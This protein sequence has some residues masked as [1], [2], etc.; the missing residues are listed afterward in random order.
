MLTPKDE[1]W[2]YDM[3]WDAIQSETD[4]DEEQEE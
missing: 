4:K 3:W 2:D 1:T